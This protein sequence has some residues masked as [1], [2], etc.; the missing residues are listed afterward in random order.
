MKTLLITGIRGIPAAHGGFETFAE[1]L[2]LYLVNLGWQVVVYCQESLSVCPHNSESFW[3]GVKLIHIPVKGNGAKATVM[4]DYLVAKDAA[5]REGL[6]LTLGYNTAVFNV[7]LR[8]QG[9]KNIINMDGI[10]WKRDKW[11]WYE[12][13]WLYLNERVGCL[14]GN[15][16]IADHPEIANHLSTRVSKTKIS[17]IPYG[18]RDVVVA[19][20]SLLEPFQLEAK[21]YVILI[22]RPEPENSILEIVSSFSSCYRGIKLVVLGSY[23][24]ANNPYH[25]SV[26]AA[27]SSEVYFIGPIY[28]HATLD[29]LRFYAMLYVHGHTVGGTNPSLIEALGASQPVLAH[30]NK[31]NRW[32]AGDEAE[33]FDGL[34]ACTL[35][36]DALLSDDHRLSIM[37]KASYERFKSE[38]LWKNVLQQYELLLSEWVS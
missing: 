37:S 20:I 14:V 30:D 5:K 19:D 33:Y 13:A 18:A 8:L 22:A 2:A 4:F 28:D 21:R 12:K 26:Q 11:C 36:F 25:A 38:F 29:A 15:H 27:A 34:A 17:V 31:Y 35:A 10:E 7:W 3:Q 6:V 32:V 16:L 23:D 24:V 9:K 1:A